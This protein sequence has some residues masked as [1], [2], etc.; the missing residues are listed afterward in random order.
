M[1]QLHFYLDSEATAQ[2][3]F[4]SFSADVDRS[5]HKGLS[6]VV[7]KSRHLGDECCNVQ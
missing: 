6:A 5:R 4:N 7:D 3:Y 2:C 1:V